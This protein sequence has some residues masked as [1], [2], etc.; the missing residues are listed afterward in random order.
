MSIA[1]LPALVQPC[2]SD[3]V[4]V[5]PLRFNASWMRSTE[6]LWHPQS[7]LQARTFSLL[8]TQRLHLPIY[9]PSIYHPSRFLPFI[10]DFFFPLPPTVA[11]HTSPVHPTFRF[12]PFA[13]CLSCRRI[14]DYPFSPF[15]GV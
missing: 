12:T 9:I 1:R 8:Q 3:P 10:Q 14:V 11:F 15:P 4:P 7:F 2:S 6:V 5:R 13:C